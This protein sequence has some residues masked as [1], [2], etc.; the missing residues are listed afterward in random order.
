MGA[1]KS[2]KPETTTETQVRLVL[3][4]EMRNVAQAIGANLPAGTGFA[5]FVFDFGEKGNLAYAS[6]A[7]RPDVVKL[8]R[9]WIEKTS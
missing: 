8:L 6:S 9:E 3:E 4:G 7:A 2:G 5:L 1:V